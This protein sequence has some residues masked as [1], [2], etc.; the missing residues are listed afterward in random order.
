MHRGSS[1][2]EKLV[3]GPRTSPAE[4]ALDPGKREVCLPAFFEDTPKTWQG[5]AGEGKEC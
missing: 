1:L 3:R 5:L 2:A 4:T